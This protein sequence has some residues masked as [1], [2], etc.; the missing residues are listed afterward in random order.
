MRVIGI[1]VVIAALGAGSWW[2][3]TKG[4]GSASWKTT[5]GS[6]VPGFNSSA[7]VAEASAEASAEGRS[8]LV[9]FSASWCPPCK[10]LKAGPLRDAAVQSW[11]AG[12]GMGLYV[13]VDKNHADAAAAKVRAVPTLALIRNGKVVRR[14]E[15]SMDTQTLLAW[16][17]AL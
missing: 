15:G 16:I 2:H 3:F 9:V 4:P 14:H 5:G 12:P 10:S 7:T 11:L 8:L 13:D 1:L 6:E 17:G